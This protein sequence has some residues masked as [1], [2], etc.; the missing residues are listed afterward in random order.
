M[1]LKGK[2]F[3]ILVNEIST[4]CRRVAR[5]LHP[6]TESN[7]TPNHEAKFGGVEHAK[8]MSAMRTL[9]PLAMM[10]E[11]RASGPLLAFVATRDAAVRNTEADLG[12]VRSISKRE[13]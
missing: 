9:L 1:L 7:R 8:S 11:T 12:K 13:G 5:R 3:K 6:G 2:C 10:P 4:I